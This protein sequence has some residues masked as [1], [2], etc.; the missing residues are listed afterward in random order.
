M[1]VIVRHGIEIDLYFSGTDYM[2][3]WDWVDVYMI[4]SMLIR[5][6]CACIPVHLCFY[7]LSQNKIVCLHKLIEA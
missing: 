5:V 1:V 4:K 7:C 3:F 6:I 2:D